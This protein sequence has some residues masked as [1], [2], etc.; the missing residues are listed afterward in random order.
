[1]AGG[2][3]I[4]RPAENGAAS[5]GEVGFAGTFVEVFNLLNF[6]PRSSSEPETLRMVTVGSLDGYPM[7]FIDGEL[8]EWT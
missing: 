4:D 5:G 3:S 1:M 2:G 7:L 6:D 8:Q